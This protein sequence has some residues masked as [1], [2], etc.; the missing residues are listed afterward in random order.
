[1]YVDLEGRTTFILQ[2][3]PILWNDKLCRQWWFTN[4]NKTNNQRI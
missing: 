3:K 2:T 4:I 1:M